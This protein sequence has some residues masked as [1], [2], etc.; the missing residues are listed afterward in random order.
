[1]GT[2]R[3]EMTAAQAAAFDRLRAQRDGR[4]TEQDI[5]ARLQAH[6]KAIQIRRLREGQTGRPQPVSPDELSDAEL[7]EMA[8][9]AIDDHPEIM[10]PPG[11]DPSF[12]QLVGTLDPGHR[13][14]LPELDREE[15]DRERW[16]K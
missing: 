9:Q 4:A 7:I 16:E 2:I 6:H 5:A 3:R 11:V 14:Y 8:F 15:S 1:M 13:I 10:H 12:D